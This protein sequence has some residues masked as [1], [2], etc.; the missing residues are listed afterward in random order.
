MCA[1]W[2]ERSIVEVHGITCCSISS[3][4]LANEDLFWISDNLVLTIAV[5]PD[6]SVDEDANVLLRTIQHEIPYTILAN[7]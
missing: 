5:V 2:Q 4:E 6:R 3:G 1:S 7:V